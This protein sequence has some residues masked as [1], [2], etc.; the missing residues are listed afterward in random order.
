MYFVDTYAMT[1]YSASGTRVQT[2]SKSMIHTFVSSP[3]AS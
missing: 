3:E 1:G 2:S